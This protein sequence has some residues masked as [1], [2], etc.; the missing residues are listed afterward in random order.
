MTEVKRFSPEAHGSDAYFRAAIEHIEGYA[1]YLLSPQGQVATWNANAQK[2]FGYS[3]EEILGKHYSVFFRPEAI[4]RGEPAWV[5]NLASAEGHHVHEVGACVRTGSQFW[6]D[7]VISALRDPSG[8][9]TGFAKITR[10]ATK[11]KVGPGPLSY[12]R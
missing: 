9:L 2:L 4:E 10:D 8:K 5:L 7:N 12:R 6:G 1:I 3:T 11:L